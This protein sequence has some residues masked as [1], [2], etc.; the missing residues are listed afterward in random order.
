MKEPRFYTFEEWL[1]KNPD[2]KKLKSLPCEECQGSG[3]CECHCLTIHECGYCEGTGKNEGIDEK[4]REQYQ[5]LKD[6][7][8]ERWNELEGVNKNDSDNNH[9][10]H[11]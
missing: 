8:L 1:D 11:S 10:Q 4:L 7:Q 5:E 9:P 3:E 2:L 6:K